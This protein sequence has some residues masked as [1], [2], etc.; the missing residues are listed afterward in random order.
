MKAIIHTRY[1]SPAV[2]QEQDVPQPSP[3]PGQ[4]L[5]KIEATAV[6]PADWHLLHGQPFLVRPS[7]GLFRPKHKVLG[8]DVAGSVETVGRDVT[9][10][11][12]GDRVFADLSAHGRGGFAEYVAAPA[13]VLA[14][15][16]TGVT[17]PA[18]AAVPMAGVTALQGLRDHGGIQPGWNVLVNGASGGVGSF[19]VQI[20]KALG[21]RVTGVCSTSKAAM[22]RSLGADH[23]VDYTQ[24]DFTAA[25]PRYDLIFDTVGNREVADYQRALAPAGVFVTT[26]FLPAL[27]FRRTGSGENRGQK[28][29]NMMAKPNRADLGVMAEMVAAGQV[30]PAIDRCFPLAQT[31]DALRYVGARRAQGKVLVLPAAR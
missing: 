2:L 7:A 17:S 31:A 28:M 16:P 10:F 8:S 6:N 19:A 21:A 5:V 29:V 4:V 22:V 26:A 25:G 18:A 1:G 15:I 11:Q 27:M 12:P 14:P 20:A 30:K 3:K 13:D 23:V 24:E 9:E